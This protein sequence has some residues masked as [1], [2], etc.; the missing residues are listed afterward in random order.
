MTQADL[1][2]TTRL[3]L[4]DTVRRSTAQPDRVLLRSIGGRHR[5]VLTPAQ[6]RVLTEGFA[7]FH[8]VP[9][10]LAHLL[11]EHHCPPLNEYYELV[12][13]AHAAGL[14][15]TGHE[16]TEYSLARNWRVRLPVRVAFWLGAIA[17]PASLVAL[18]LKPWHAPAG[19]VDWLAG[20]LA[21]GAF[22]SM[23]EVLA[24]CALAGGGCEVRSPRLHGLTL[25]PHFRVDT[26]E[27]AMGGRD[28]E[29]AVAGLRLLPVAAGAALLAWQQPGW[30]VPV[31]AALLYGL[32]PWRGSAAA[33]WR[34]AQLGSP[35]FSVGAGFLFAPRR[36]DTWSRWRA[37]WAGMRPATAGH[38]VAWV[39]LTGLVFA[40]SLP[41][42]AA[43]LFAW[44]APAGRLHP[45]VSV[46]LYSLIAGTLVAGGALARAGLVH[47]WLGRKLTR[48]LRAQTANATAAALQG[49]IP[50][51][52]RQMALFQTLA[53]DDLAALA[54]TMQ[55]VEVAKRAEVFHE[56][57]PGDAFYVVL[58]GEL[59]VLKQPRGKK[60]RPE[61]IGRLGPGAGFGEIALLENA[62]RSATVRATRP[63]RLLR[64]AKADFD[65]LVVGRVGATRVRELLQYA[66]FLGR[67][68][69]LAGW[70]FDDLV[71]YA[72]GCG[73]VSVPAGGVVLQRGSANIWFYLIYDGAFEARAGSRVLRRMH[74]GDY[75][76]EI[77][78]LGNVEATADVV[79]VEESRCL[80]MSREHF[81]GFF[82]QDYRIG[83]RMEALAAQRLG[84]R[85]FVS[86]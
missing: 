26:A 72:Q 71:R 50:A 21:A 39:L 83:L 58:A 66:T 15:V 84:K 86:R 85:L 14:L 6:A 13:Q 5:L 75:F 10:T 70:P 54:A 4:H 1:L 63:C 20:W 49:D 44:F 34:K 22:L 56:D 79:A 41:E 23:G 82:A 74:P 78:L 68:V 55:P 40:R 18:G 19:W 25:L 69:F 30:L 53:E 51:V 27:A 76:G 36:Q 37:W 2:S 28:C 73:T 47:W 3:R 59:D 24:G 48:P 16:P 11:A 12:L 62:A 52:L 17:I 64:L 8:T 9:E 67:L 65:G 80:T 77:S 45:L 32:A 42:P 81:L 38:W 35:R 31:L 61:R 7:E 33:Q 43:A 46:G 57:D 29:R 60:G